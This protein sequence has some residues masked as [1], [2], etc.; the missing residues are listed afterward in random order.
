MAFDG[1]MAPGFPKARDPWE[2]LPIRWKKSLSL[3][4]MP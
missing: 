2:S 4:A 3:V 1:I